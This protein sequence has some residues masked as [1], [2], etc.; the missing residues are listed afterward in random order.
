VQQRGCLISGVDTAANPQLAPAEAACGTNLKPIR[1][2]W[3]LVRDTAAVSGFTFLAKIGG[4]AKTVVI[5]RFFGTSAA[6]DAYLIAFLAPSFLVDVLSGA[7]VPALVPRLVDARHHSGRPGLIALY[8]HTFRRSVIKL[9]I[10][11]LTV[12]TLAA[13]LLSQ[14]AIPQPQRSRLITELLLIML[15]ILPMSAVANVWR[16]VLNAE[17]RFAFAAA[18]PLCTPLA[19]I[20]FVLAAG[21]WRSSY[22]LAAGT[23]FGAALELLVLRHALR[24]AALPA[25]PPPQL[26]SAPQ[27]GVRGQYYAI[28][29]TNA[30]T[31][32]SPFVD[33]CMATMLSSGISILS[34][35]TRVTGVLLSIGPAALSVA[36]LPRFSRLTAEK[37][38]RRLRQYLFVMLGVAMAAMSV[39]TVLLIAFSHTIV[40]TVFEHGAFTP[41]N[42][43]TVALVQQCSLLQL[44]IAV[45]V[46]ILTRLVIAAGANRLL[47]PLSAAALA[48]TAGFDY[49][50]MA[51]FGIAGIAL[52]TFFVQTLLFGA[53]M[54]VAF[55]C[56]SIGLSR[57]GLG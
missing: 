10:V 49:L 26:H 52:S 46:T 39:L 4:A 42:T 22:L 17:G 40:R 37:D 35:G 57:G 53:L 33:Q 21:P 43:S 56:R 31:C 32:G 36:I 3:G 8:S 50:L 24:A 45:G 55:R 30:V 27:T 25:F 18:A 1:R 38:S 28:A 41:A 12:A 14:G 16:A 29:A 13:L 51:R 20:A 2:R 11:S 47:V 54:T 19:I 48:A 6:F 23:T 44:P 34:L 7:L 5:A 9:S 15:P